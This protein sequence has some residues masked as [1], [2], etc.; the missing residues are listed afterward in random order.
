[1]Q[2][3]HGMEV[4]HSLASKQTCVA[5]GVMIEWQAFA[6]LIVLTGGEDIVV[7]VVGKE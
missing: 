7:D 2:T 3:L 4:D 6:Q 5:L 1:M